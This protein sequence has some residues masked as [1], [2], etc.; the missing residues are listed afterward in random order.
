MSQPTRQ[1]CARGGTLSGA[2][3]RFTRLLGV[4]LALVTAHCTFPEYDTHLAAGG[5][6]SGATVVAG[7]GGNAAAAQAGT[8]AEPLGG[9]ADNLVGGAGVA[10]DATPVGGSS[11]CVGEQ[12]PVAQCSGGCLERYPEHCYD[13]E[14]SGDEVDVDCGGGCQ[15]CTNELC[16]T[17]ADCMSGT[18]V[19]EA[20]G[21][22]S[23]Y[24][25]LSLTFT[26]HE[27]SASVGSTAYTLV[28]QNEESAGGLNFS[29]KDL[30]IRYYF[31]RS[32]IVEP[33]IVRATQSI[34]Q[35]ASGESRELQNTTW[36]IVRTEDAADTVYDGYVEVGLG[37]SGKLFPGDHFQLYQ[38]MLT[39]DP[40]SSSFDQRA[41]YSF[42][43]N[44]GSA[45]LHVTMLYKGKLIWG[46]EPRPSNPRACFVRGV[47]L[48][49]PALTVDG[50][51]WQGAADAAISTN[52]SGI[53][54]SDAPFPLVTGSAAS[55]LSTATKLQAGNELSLPTENGAYFAYLWAMS[56]SNDAAPS[57]FTVQGVEADITSK[58]RSQSTDGGQVWARMGP[59]RVQVLTG[60]VTL[61]VTSGAVNFAGME[62][63]YLE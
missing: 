52:G 35:L 53:T 32:G 26:A 37:E 12:W 58:F 10:G 31:E 8:G 33:L 3:A 5:S 41:N 4:A 59:F 14:L 50:N 38:Q 60:K 45:W 7:S 11:Q 62:L 47:N 2:E 25:P 21:V 28:V 13:D 44:D 1:K 20:S 57:T 63:W 19:A 48:N 49:G 42:T 6:S 40:A 9:M 56:T 15:A 55:V 54:V 29:F 30:K 22:S 23:C 61:G 17:A 27:H 34:L 46:L 24:A 43:D 16:K 39:G 18:C 51:A 36:T